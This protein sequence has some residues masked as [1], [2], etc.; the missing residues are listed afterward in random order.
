[1]D[2]KPYLFLIIPVAA[3]IIFQ[4][5]IGGDESKTLQVPIQEN[6]FFDP[7]C[8]GNQTL[9]IDNS[10]I[11]GQSDI[12]ALF[13]G[14]STN[15]DVDEKSYLENHAKILFMKIPV[16]IPDYNPLNKI[17][18]NNAKLSLMTQYMLVNYSQP[19]DKFFVINGMCVNTSW[20]EKTPMKDLPCI[21]KEKFPNVI[22]G[23]FSEPFKP[24]LITKINLDL[25][26]HIEIAQQ[27]NIHSFTEMIEFDPVS[28]ATGSYF[29]NHQRDCLYKAQSDS[30]T[31]NCVA[32][33]HIGVYSANYP[34]TGVRPQLIVEYDKRPTDQAQAVSIA[35]FAFIPTLASFIHYRQKNNKNKIDNSDT[36]YH[37][38][39]SDKLARRLAFIGVWRGAAISIGSAFLAVGA[40]LNFSIIPTLRDYILKGASE[41]DFTFLNSMAN[42]AG[43]LMYSGIIIIILTV[44]GAYVE[45]YRKR[46]K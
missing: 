38:E 25:K 12:G 2:W 40:S 13:L 35:M 46:V 3:A 10:A 26:S 6:T 28:F 43:F 23:T 42:L 18:I 16:Q 20:S 44:I 9:K 36:N 33:N 37:V 27:Y 32:E 24:R 29:N 21:D 39:D 7:V 14:S 5:I 22:L 17:T 34:M 45:I 19:E 11:C 1:M 15:L 41:N 31:N 8:V 4:S 30:G